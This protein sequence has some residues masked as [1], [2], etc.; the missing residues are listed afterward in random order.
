M[1]TQIAIK[2]VE[3]ANARFEQR[4]RARKVPKTQVF[5]EYVTRIKEIIS[6]HKGTTIEC[7]MV[8]KAAIYLA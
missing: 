2:E 5:I 7:R 3:A 6:A 4:I 1:A 8:K